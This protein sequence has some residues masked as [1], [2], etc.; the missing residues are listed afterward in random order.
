MQVLE[1]Q[2]KPLVQ[3]KEYLAQL[4]KIKIAKAEKCG[5]LQAELEELEKPFN[6]E[7]E[8]ITNELL[9]LMQNDVRATIKTDCGIAKFR[10]GT[11]RRS[12][13]RKDLDAFIDEHPEFEEIRRLRK[14][15]KSADSVCVEVY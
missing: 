10:E 9:K 4:Q 13:P 6:L 11:I 8:A 7:S 15:T 12:Y 1:Q 5:Q 14:E 2:V 3:V